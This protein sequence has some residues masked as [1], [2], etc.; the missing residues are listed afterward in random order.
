MIDEGKSVSTSGRFK[1]S[2]NPTCVSAGLKIR[3]VP[4]RKEMAEN[5]NGRIF[6]QVP[7]TLVTT[8]PPVPMM[9]F[10]SGKTMPAMWIESSVLLIVMSACHQSAI[11]ERRGRLDQTGHKD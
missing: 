6:R 11:A 4:S 10:D 5:P 1:T 8:L 2:A 9:D 7:I 3:A